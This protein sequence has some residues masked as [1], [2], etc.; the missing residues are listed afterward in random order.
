MGKISKSFREH[1]SVHNNI[2]GSNDILSASITS[3]A[4]GVDSRLKIQDPSSPSPRKSANGF[5]ESQ[6]S[7]SSRCSACRVKRL[8]VSPAEILHTAVVGADVNSTIEQHSACSQTDLLDVMVPD[9]ERQLCTERAEMEREDLRQQLLSIIQNQSARLSELAVELRDATA[10]LQ[11]EREMRSSL[12][13]SI[14]EDGNRSKEAE[15]MAK[16]KKKEDEEEAAHALK[17]ERSVYL[18]YKD[19]VA[20]EISQHKAETALLR[21]QLEDLRLSLEQRQ[22]AQQSAEQPGPAVDSEVRLLR[23]QSQRDRDALAELRGEIGTLTAAADAALLRE[24]AWQAERSELLFLANRRDEQLR[25]LKYETSCLQR[26]LAQRDG[27]V[28]GQGRVTELEQML[29]DLQVREYRCQLEIANLKLQLVGKS[30][31]MFS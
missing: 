1:F 17:A 24:R 11:A 22:K 3:I 21:G 16:R 30:H 7:P 6:V 14:V 13:S 25:S 12:L 29:A 20:Q 28:E 18:E 2:P 26:R 19:R 15:E 10:S 31:S 27:H 5:S 4:N 23:A 9:S 8:V